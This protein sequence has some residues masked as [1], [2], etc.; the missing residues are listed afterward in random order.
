METGRCN[1]I[2]ARQAGRKLRVKLTM[3]GGLAHMPGLAKPL[4][5]DSSQLSAE[6][7][8]ELQRLCD[9]LPAKPKQKPA[10]KAPP[11]PD[12]RCYTLTIEAG[13][14]R[15]EVS[16]ADPIDHPA[17]ADLIAFVRRCGRVS[18]AGEAKS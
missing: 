7:S 16:A 13:A 9:A 2:A 5:V 15:R 3:D 10:R 14:K 12:A 4:V 1:V 11:M 8:A 18:E 17:I 6:N